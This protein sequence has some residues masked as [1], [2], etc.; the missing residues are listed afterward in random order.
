MTPDEIEQKYKTKLSYPTRPEVPGKLK[1]QLKERDVVNFLRGY[2]LKV[3][4]TIV[5]LFY[6]KNIRKNLDICME[7][8]FSVLCIINCV[9]YY[10]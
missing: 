1:H 5:L 9:C 8:V 3:N 4:N 6:E 2:K 7:N 10:F